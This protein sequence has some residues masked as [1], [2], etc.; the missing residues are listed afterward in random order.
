MT[1][2]DARTK[3]YDKLAMPARRHVEACPRFATTEE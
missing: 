3:Q 1:A 2:R